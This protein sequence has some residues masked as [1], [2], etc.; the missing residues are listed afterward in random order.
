MPV[1][2]LLVIIFAVVFGIAAGLT[3]ISG[4]G[5]IGS[6]SNGKVRELQTALRN[7]Q[8]MERLATKGLRAIANGAGNPVY[9]AQDALYQIEKIESKELN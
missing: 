7:S 6:R 1:I 8:T 4:A 9:E 2:I 3:I 5:S